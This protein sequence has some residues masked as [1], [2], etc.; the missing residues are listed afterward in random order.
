MT[1]NQTRRSLYLLQRSIGDVQVAQR[2]K[3]PKRLIRRAVTRKALI[4]WGKL[5]K[6]L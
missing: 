3:L 5:W 2:G 4:P 1:L 6:A